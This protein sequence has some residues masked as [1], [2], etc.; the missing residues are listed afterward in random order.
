[1]QL[2]L[3]LL[4]I[5]TLLVGCSASPNQ[6]VAAADAPTEELAVPG[7]SPGARPG[8]LQGEELLQALARVAQSA[9]KKDDQGRA[10]LLEFA[11]H[12][13][14]LVRIQAVKSLTDEF[15]RKDDVVYAAIVT[16]L[17][18]EFWLVR[19]FAVRALARDTRPESL[20]AIRRRLEV[21][22][23]ERVQRHLKNAL[24]KHSGE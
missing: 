18:D 1:M 24:A 17:D 22:E 2:R 11:K 8:E 12:P 16:A 23:N 6:S 21:E 20:A 19:S 10:E 9:R 7:G 15:Y 4:L 14:Y 5:A 13:D 3:T